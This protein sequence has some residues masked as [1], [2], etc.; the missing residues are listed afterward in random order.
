MGAIY[1]L[2]AMLCL[3]LIASFNLTL[4]KVCDVT[5]DIIVV[6]SQRAR[7]QLACDTL[8]ETLSA[9]LA[10]L[11]DDA[12]RREHLRAALAN[13]RY[14]D[15]RSGYFF[16][17]E[18]TVAV[19]YPI[20]PAKVGTDM[21]GMQDPRG[22]AVVAELA[23]IGANGGGFLDYVWDKP[24]QGEVPKISYAQGIAGTPFII[25]T[26]VY[27][28]TVAAQQSAIVQEMTAS[29][30]EYRIFIWVFGAMLAGATILVAW[31]IGRSVVG[32]MERLMRDLG[33]SADELAAASNNISSAGAHLASGAT[34][35]AAAIETTSGSVDEI[36]TMIT[37]NAEDAGS[38]HRSMQA[39]N[40]VIDQAS[41]AIGELKNAMHSIEGSSQE[42]QKIIKTIDE[43][44][45]QTNLLAL[46]AAVEAARAG[47][48]GA[49]FAVVADEVRSLAFRAAEA[50]RS[51]TELIEGSVHQI[52]Q[53]SG[54]LNTASAAFE[55][56]MKHA[57][58]IGSRLAGIAEAS[59]EQASSIQRIRHSMTEMDAVTKESTAALEETASAAEEA[60]AQAQDL[61]KVAWQIDAVVHGVHRT[62]ANSSKQQAARPKPAAPRSRS[63]RTVPSRDLVGVG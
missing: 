17:F 3:G 37:R 32:P 10:G 23:R 59:Q 12:A 49:G 24:G 5:K 63:G 22:T 55:G 21:G 19:A 15:D 61:R 39:A 34:Q 62:A 43:I 20:D 8:A 13:V 47:E 16:A 1:L 50:A 41:A 26:G 36:S 52:G 40:V 44:A 42:T 11:P 35:Q 53:G 60:S 48:A 46:N 58:E 56:V 29:V 6:G 27:V 38:A 31:L 57:S 2:V 51:T 7:L 45:F 33:A 54:S 4:Q 14:E 28:D 9:Q 18:D 30:S 25:G